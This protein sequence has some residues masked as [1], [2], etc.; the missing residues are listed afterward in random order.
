MAKIDLNE[1]TPYIALI[2]SVASPIITTLL[3]NKHQL[4]LHNAEFY[5]LHRAEVIE[6]YLQTIGLLLKNRTPENLEAY[7]K[8]FGEIF[9][10]IPEKHWKLIEIID[11]S[12]NNENSTAGARNNVKELCKQLS[13]KPPRFKY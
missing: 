13:K 8:C 5:S 2:I 6:H 9:F 1:I 10:Y 3:N 12:I 11:H 7:N 4:K